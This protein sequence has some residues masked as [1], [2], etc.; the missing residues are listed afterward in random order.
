PY[1]VF[2]YENNELKVENELACTL[3]EECVKFCP[4]ITVEPEPDKY[5]LELESVGSLD[6]RRILIEATKSI[7]NKVEELKKKVEAQ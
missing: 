3:C 4:G 1:K 5:V 6:P 7:L 2:S